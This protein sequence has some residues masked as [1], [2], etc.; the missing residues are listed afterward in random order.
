MLRPRWAVAWAAFFNLIAFA[1]F[2][3]LVANTVAATVKEDFV[4]ATDRDR[5]PTTSTGAPCPTGPPPR[6]LAAAL[7]IPVVRLIPAPW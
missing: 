3:T 7:S 1:I 5:S 2:G 6:S 4:G